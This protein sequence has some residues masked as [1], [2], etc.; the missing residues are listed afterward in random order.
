[1]QWPPIFVVWR[2]NASTA[3]IRVLSHEK[4]LKPIESAQLHIHPGLIKCAPLSW[5]TNS[6][7]LSTETTTPPPTSPGVNE[8]ST[9]M[10][11]LLYDM[12]NV[13]HQNSSLYMVLTVKGCMVPFW[14]RSSFTETRKCWGR[15]IFKACKLCNPKRY[16]G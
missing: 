8:G 14:G 5:V 16:S 1:M 7:C 13:F 2:T 4:G 12:K 9:N 6:H 11:I 15:A 10:H 3:G